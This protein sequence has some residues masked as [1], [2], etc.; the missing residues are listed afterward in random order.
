MI[1]FIIGR[2]FQSHIAACHAHFHFDDFF[3]LDLERCSQV[4]D[5]IRCHRIQARLVTTQ[6]KK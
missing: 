2:R 1:V 4:I 3:T 6:I 5:L